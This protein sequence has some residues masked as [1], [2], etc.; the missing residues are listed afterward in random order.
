VEHDEV[1][2][3]GRRLKDLR[4]RRRLNQ[5]DV[6]ERAGVSQAL[7]SQAERNG[8]GLTVGTLAAIAKALGSDVSEFLTLPPARQVFNVAAAAWQSYDQAAV[9]YD[10]LKTEAVK[11]A[12]FIK[13]HRA[14]IAGLSRLSAPDRQDVNRWD[15]SEFREAV[16]TRAPA[17]KLDLA[18][19]RAFP[20][21]DAAGHR[22]QSILQL[23]DECATLDDV[24]IDLLRM[25]ARRLSGS[26]S[27]ANTKSSAETAPGA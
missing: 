13:R 23:V 24:D 8:R 6:A 5:R 15:S 16:F 11:M 1:P 2:N 17:D 26:S 18:A 7:I 25:M 27:M 3:I 14:E 19:Y 10:W 20:V 9:A 12:D 22:L 4:E 21:G